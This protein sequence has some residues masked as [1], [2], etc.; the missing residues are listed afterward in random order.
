MIYI[1][2]YMQ[3]MLIVKHRLWGFSQEFGKSALS[4]KKWDVGNRFDS[5]N[6]TFL[7]KHDK[8]DMFF[9]TSA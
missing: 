6:L 5:N 1:Y 9:S 8:H 3:L 2:I 4:T 7:Y